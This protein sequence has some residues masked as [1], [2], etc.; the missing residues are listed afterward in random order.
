MTVFNC[1]KNAVIEKYEVDWAAEAALNAAGQLFSSK[2]PEPAPRRL[3]PTR[4][5]PIKDIDLLLTY[6]AKVISNLDCN[7]LLVHIW[8]GAQTEH[9]FKLDLETEKQEI[10]E[11]GKFMKIS[12][13]F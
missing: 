8:R 6:K 7:K 2:H 9:F 1:T 12:P 4:N 5:I 10:V 13:D 3:K 11:P